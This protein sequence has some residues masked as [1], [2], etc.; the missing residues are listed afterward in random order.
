MGIGSGWLRVIRGWIFS[1]DATSEASPMLEGMPGIEIQMPNQL[2]MPNM[3][4][5][6]PLVLLEDCP[7]LRREK[8][9]YTRTTRPRDDA[10]ITQV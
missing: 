3:K 9:P 10:V 8:P 4:K 6:F 7:P 1:E 2:P 5:I